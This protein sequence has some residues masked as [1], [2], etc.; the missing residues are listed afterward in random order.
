MQYACVY[1]C[2]TYCRCSNL[3]THSSE[4][5]ISPIDLSLFGWF[6]STIYSEY[7]HI[8][9]WMCCSVLGST[10]RALTSSYSYKFIVI[11]TPFD[12]HH[13]ILTVIG[14][15]VHVRCTYIICI[16]AYM[17]KV[18]SI[19]VWLKK[20]YFVWKVPLIFNDIQQ[21]SLNLIQVTFL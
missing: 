11:D 14:W 3:D 6:F 8:C 5:M 15:K 18:Y 16:F 4:W 13:F 19:V 21:S 17:W 9:E 10:Y 2:C 1:M 12:I 7:L 20:Q